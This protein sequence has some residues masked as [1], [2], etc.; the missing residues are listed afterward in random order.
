MKRLRHRRD[1]LRR[2]PR[3]GEAGRGGRHERPVRVTVP[4][5]RAGSRRWRAST[6]SRCGADVLDRS[7]MRRALEG[8]DVLFHAAGHGGVAAA[9]ARSGASTPSRRGSPS[10][11]AAEAGVR[12]VVLTSSVAAIGPAPRGAPAD[13]RAHLSRGRH[14]PDLRRL[15]ARGRAWPRFA[16]GERL[17]VEVVAVNPAYVLGR[18]A[19]PLAARR[20]LDA[21]RRQLPARPAAGDRR[22]L[23][24]H[25]RRRGRRGRSPARGPSAASPASATS[26]AARTCA[27]RR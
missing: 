13:E 26:S 22:L 8:C 6:S 15:Q 27:G 11:R 18:A 16:A 9:S 24:E 3:G 17:G 20:D 21:D 2:R 1:R 5:P 12:R 7:S 19:Q 25:R 23:H 10:R 4:R 14:R